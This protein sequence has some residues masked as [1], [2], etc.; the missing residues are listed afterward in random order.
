LVKELK[1]Q[2]DYNLCFEVIQ[3]NTSRSDARFKLAFFSRLDLSISTNLPSAVSIFT[4]LEVLVCIVV[5]ADDIN[6][7]DAIAEKN[8]FKKF[9]RLF[10]SLLFMRVVLSVNYQR[11]YYYSMMAIMEINDTNH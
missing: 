11:V 7:I 10:F 1:F 3:L 9:L 8:I 5:L 4:L 2:K 6:S